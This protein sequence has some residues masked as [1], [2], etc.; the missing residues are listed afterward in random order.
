MGQNADLGDDILDFIVGVLD[1]DNLD[2]DSLAG[3]FVDSRDE[4]SAI[5]AQAVRR[6]PSTPVGLT[7]CIP[8]QNCP[9]LY[10]DHAI[11]RNQISLFPAK[12][13][14]KTAQIATSFGILRQEESRQATEDVL[15]CSYRCSSVS[16]TTPPGQQSRPC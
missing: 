1:V 3:A 13:I 8:F 16:C 10:I 14:N 11:S 12:R 6:T 9:L 15:I 5:L 4:L 2:G 7:L